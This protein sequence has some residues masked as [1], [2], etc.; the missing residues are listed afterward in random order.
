M[1]S[2]FR[3]VV[4]TLCVYGYEYVCVHRCPRQDMTFCWKCMFKVMHHLL[5]CIRALSLLPF[6]YVDIRRVEWCGQL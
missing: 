4:Y 6:L 5:M 1:V 2:K 3:A